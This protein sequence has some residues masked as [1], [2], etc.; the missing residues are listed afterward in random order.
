[1]FILNSHD[2]TGEIA[3]A[4]GIRYGF[5]TWNQVNAIN[6]EIG[7]AYPISYHNQR[8]LT[9]YC[10]HL[11][12]FEGYNR[13][14]CSVMNTNSHNRQQP[15]DMHWD[16]SGKDWALLIPVIVLSIVLFVCLNL[17]LILL[18]ALLCCWRKRRLAS[19]HFH[20]LKEELNM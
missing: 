2:R 12:H 16:E 1:M 13:L 6:L 10:Y 14:Q 18:V 17:V 8:A 5:L 19:Q 15:D 4:W 20:K 3:G 7:N 9:W 11:Q